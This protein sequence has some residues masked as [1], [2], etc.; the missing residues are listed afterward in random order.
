[1]NIKKIILGFAVIIMSSSAFAQQQMPCFEDTVAG[2]NAAVAKGVAIEQNRRN[3]LNQQAKSF[4]DELAQG[5]EQCLDTIK[6][7]GNVPLAIN[8][9]TQEALKQLIKQVLG[10]ICN[11]ATSRARGIRDQVNKDI[12]VDSGIPGFP[13]VGGGIGSGSSGSG[14][15][16]NGSFGGVTVNGGVVTS[17]SQIPGVVGF[18]SN[19][20]SPSFEQ[21]QITPAA[22]PA[23]DKSM[24]DSVK[25]FFGGAQ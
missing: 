14:V 15:G 22:Q 12:Y 4:G 23:Q 8:M 3:V 2:I 24:L 16:S 9:P 20:L 11:E 25:N 10:Q 13:G 1:M 7:L 18:T 17:G 19:Q 21:Q 5:V 6:Q